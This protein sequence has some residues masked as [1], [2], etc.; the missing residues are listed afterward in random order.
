MSVDQLHRVA[1]GDAM[2]RANLS[3]AQPL[4]MKYADPSIMPGPIEYYTLPPA[5]ESNP[6]PPMMA[7]LHNHVNEGPKPATGGGRKRK[8]LTSLDEDIAAYKQN[9]DHIISTDAF[10]DEELPTCQTVRARIN[11]LIDSGIM[12]KTEFT[13]AICCNSNSLSRF[14]H[15][16]GPMGGAGSNVYYN[17]W[18]WFRQ[19]EYAK[20]K[21]PDVKKRQRLEAESSG[22]VGGPYHNNNNNSSS[23]TAGTGRRKPGPAARTVTGLPDISGIH[24]P[25][26]ET[27]DVP[28]YE[29]CDE[30]R[31]KINAH[32]KTPGLTQAQF[33][34]DLYAQLNAPK[35]K[36]IQSKQLADFRNLKGPRAGARSS[37]F[38]AAYVYFEKL[39]I[40]QNKPMSA[41]R[42][43]MEELWAAEGGFSRREDH[44]TMYIGLSNMPMYMDQFGMMANTG[45]Y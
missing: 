39:R 13:K 23:T 18:A 25:G 7:M 44:R 2:N 9:L 45:Y 43:T 3:P 8:V 26:E 14:M 4:N 42:M 28:V 37:V 5:L 31:K 11:R 20:L 36:G 29:S 40:A 27:D 17:A 16:T 10:E 21:M 12:N 1:L 19:R 22:P 33:C 15:S 30:I 32:L 6:P 34:R 41:H 35:C 24:L 38:Y